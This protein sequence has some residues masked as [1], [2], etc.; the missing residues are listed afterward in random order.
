MKKEIGGF[1][2]IN[3]IPGK[4]N[5]FHKDAIR[6]NSARNAFLY[7]AKAKNIK[8]IY[9]PRYLCEAVFNVCL[10]NNIKIHFYDFEGFDKPVDYYIK[11]APKNAFF[12]FVN[13]Y[14]LYGNEF[15]KRLKEF[16]PNLI[17][18]NVQAYFQP[19]VENIDTFYTCRKYFG[20]PDGA[21]LYTDIN[22]SE[23]LP[24]SDSSTRFDFLYGRLQHSASEFYSGFLKNEEY[25]NNARLEEMSLRTFQ[26]LSNINQIETKVLRENNYKY[27][28][29]KLV[30]FNELGLLK[31]VEGP[32]CFPFKN[33]YANE[34][35]K[36]LLKYKI[37]I[38]TLW[39]NVLKE[40]SLEKQYAE[41]ILPLP[42]DQRYGKEEMDFIV[43]KINEF[44]SKKHY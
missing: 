13:Y 38:P 10:N 40:K 15:I 43:S 6:L 37:Y 25:I 30:K 22:L 28:N 17:V 36:E 39:P 3:T 35:K 1:I 9:L 8:E 20:V 26:E 33:K 21:F 32:Y 4:G 16:Y 24:S 11:L 5:L 42:C 41:E 34:L 27:L 12:Y 7:L 23:K 29:E 2:E 18:D 14:G 31:D 44:F 19:P